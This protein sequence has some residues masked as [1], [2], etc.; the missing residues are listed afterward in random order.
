MAKLTNKLG[1]QSSLDNFDKIDNYVYIN[2][3]PFYRKKLK[4]F[5]GQKYLVT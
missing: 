3:K 5:R 2:N 4:D 1:S